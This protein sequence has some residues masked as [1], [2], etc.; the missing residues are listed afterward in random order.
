MNS[1]PASALARRTVQASANAAGAIHRSTI[2][3]Q[4]SSSE[5]GRHVAVLAD[6]VPLAHVRNVPATPLETRNLAWVSIPA[7]AGSNL[8]AASQIICRG[9]IRHST[10]ACVLFLVLTEKN[11]EAEVDS[12]RL[13]E[14]VK[15]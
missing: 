1:Q 6:E 2:N 9:E 13:S 10:V 11:S 5:W 12:Y 15:W 4:R 7:R 3:D 8:V 14:V